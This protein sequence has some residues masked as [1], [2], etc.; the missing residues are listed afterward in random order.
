MASGYVKPLNKPEETEDGIPDYMIDITNGET[1]HMFMVMASDWFGDADDYRP[2]VRALIRDNVEE[3][4]IYLNRITKQVMS[5]FD[6]ATHPSPEAQ[7]ERFYHG[8]VL[9]LLAELTGRYTLRS[10]RESGYGRYDVSLIPR[11][12][13]KT[14]DTDNGIIIEF[15]VMS[16]DEGEKTLEDTAKAALRQIEAKEY[17]T[18]LRAQGIKA[19]R[20]KKYGFAFEG[21]KVLILAK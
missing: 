4:N 3:M 2:F 1:R 8:L 15:K 19:E 21:K 13:S 5:F 20:V 18:E 17:D 10:N 6:S 9:G 7:P 11:M 12:D 14:R 16:P